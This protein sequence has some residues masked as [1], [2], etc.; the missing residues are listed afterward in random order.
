[1]CALARDRVFGCVSMCARAIVCARVCVCVCVCVRARARV[2]VC[3]SVRARGHARRV[4][5][6]P[7]HVQGSD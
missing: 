1:M 7:V 5:V 6:T 4:K 3:M 2:S